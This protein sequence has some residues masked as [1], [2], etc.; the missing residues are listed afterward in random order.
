MRKFSKNFV[1]PNWDA[2]IEKRNPAEDSTNKRPKESKTTAAHPAP[3]MFHY[4]VFAAD[5][6]GC[7]LSGC[8]KLPWDAVNCRRAVNRRML[9]QAAVICREWPSR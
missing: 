6:L 2:G 4:R 8:R 3:F 1:Y 5:P 9:S 7:A